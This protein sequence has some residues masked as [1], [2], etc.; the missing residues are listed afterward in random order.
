MANNAPFQ[1]EIIMESVKLKISYA[2][3]LLMVYAK[4]CIETDDPIP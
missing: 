4:V 1:L 3:L 2:C